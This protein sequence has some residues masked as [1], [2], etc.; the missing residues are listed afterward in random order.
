MFRTVTV[1]R[2]E[3]VSVKENRMAVTG[4]DGALR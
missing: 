3:K 2:G 1:Y 4:E